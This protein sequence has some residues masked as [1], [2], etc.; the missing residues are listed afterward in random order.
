MM[1]L[2]I[3]F[4]EKKY[5]ELCDLCDNK[6][7]CSYNN[8]HHHGHIGALQ[9]LARGGK[10]TYVAL[11]YVQEYLKVSRTLNFYLRNSYSRNSSCV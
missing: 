7:A 4:S 2:I 5:P 8:N 9:C 6:M 3:Y 1:T 11:K 10:V